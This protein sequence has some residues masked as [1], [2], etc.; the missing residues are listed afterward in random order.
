MKN[1]K[2]IKQIFMKMCVYLNVGACNTKL[3][4]P[5]VMQRQTFVSDICM[6]DAVFGAETVP[7]CGRERVTRL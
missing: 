4:P 3:K 6:S 7:M 5:T 2:M 1:E